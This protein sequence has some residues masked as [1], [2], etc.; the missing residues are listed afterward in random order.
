M[1]DLTGCPDL[2]SEAVG[3]NST[4]PLGET[5]SLMQDVVRQL[6]TVWNP[7]LLVCVG[8]CT[9]FTGKEAEVQVEELLFPN[10]TL[11]GKSLI[12]KVGGRSQGSLQTGTQRGLCPTKATQLCLQEK[13]LSEAP[14]LRPL[15]ITYPQPLL[16][17]TRPISSPETAT[18]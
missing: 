8:G 14:S 11:W 2:A 6:G 12:S 16:V 18:L 5:Q 3:E 9:H 7:G 4:S 1:E 15:S 13:S 17:L 10:W